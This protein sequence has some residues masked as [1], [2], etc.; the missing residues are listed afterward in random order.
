MMEEN[1]SEH[2]EET[3][4]ETTAADNREAAETAAAEGSPAP[5]SEPEK[6]MEAEPEPIPAEEA[7]ERIAEAGPA[8]EE[9][10]L[11]A[12]KAMSREEVMEL[13]RTEMAAQP[14]S[15]KSH[16]LM[17]AGLA[18]LVGLGAGFGGGYAAYE[19]LQPEIGEPAEEPQSSLPENTQPVS[20]AYTGNEL[21]IQQIAAKA[22]PSVVEIRTEVKG[23][24]YAFGFFGGEYT[25]EAAGSGVIL[26]DDGYII[27]NNHV[28]K[29]AETITVTLYD[30]TEYPAELVGTDSKSDI[31]VIRIDAADL[32][33]AVPGDSSALQVG[34]TAVVIGNPLG[35]L[36]GTVTNGI[37]SA[38]SREV[39]INREAMTLIQTNAAINSG[40]SGGGLFNGYGELIGIVN[41]KDSG[42]T[43]SGATIEGLGFAIPINEALDVA[44]QLIEKG[45][46]TDRA[47]IGIM[48]STVTET[49]GRRTPGLYI[50]EVLKGTGAEN[51]GLKAGDRII[52]VDGQD[53]DTYEKLS[54]Y[55]K[56]KDIGDTISL[57]IIRDEKEM[58]VAVTLGEAQNAKARE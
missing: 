27:T 56:G 23:S 26:S 46:V 45:Y 52:A 1:Y 16:P 44:E 50:S 32:P 29:D 8:P 40:N 19:R 54:R 5:L 28:V 53:A 43:S 33:P 55:L 22:A 35:T 21:S 6:A 20:A 37:I 9:I 24:Y 13:I 3:T 4:L 34:D 15:S 18:A 38:T 10:K 49:D 39:T 11:P 12:D 36:G 7:P 51:A 42:T 41:A 25:S 30:G 58:T 14:K 31:A 47:T 2:T 48:L 57:T 17:I